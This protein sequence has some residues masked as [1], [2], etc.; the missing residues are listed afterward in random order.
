MLFNIISI[1]AVTLNT[2]NKV[3]ECAEQKPMQVERRESLSSF[4][5]GTDQ[6][7]ITLYKYFKGSPLEWH[8]LFPNYKMVHL[9]M[10]D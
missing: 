10:N 9:G 6:I 2:N 7:E 4:N 1:K 3:D 5:I 8:N